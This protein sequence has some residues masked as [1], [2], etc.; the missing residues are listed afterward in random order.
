MV[1]TICRAL[2]L[3]AAAACLAGCAGTIPADPSKMTA[4]QIKAMAADRSA[5]ATCTVVNSPWG[6]GRT[7]YV[8]L[9][10]ATIPAG[11]V[12]VAADCSV[13]VQATPAPAKA[14]A[15]PRGAP[16]VARPEDL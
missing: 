1:K 7:I 5:V 12:S 8:Q 2:M 11:T 9:D 10:K 15:A 3:A 14:A 4:D 6:V 16:V 13:T